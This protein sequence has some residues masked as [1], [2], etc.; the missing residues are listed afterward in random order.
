MK[1]LSNI[2]LIANPICLGLM[3]IFFFSPYWF[4][5]WVFPVIIYY[6]FKLHFYVYREEHAEYDIQLEELK[7]THTYLGLTTEN[8]EVEQAWENNVTKEIIFI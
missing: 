5:F 1:I 7:K 3:I 2:L 8:Y 6:N 4:L